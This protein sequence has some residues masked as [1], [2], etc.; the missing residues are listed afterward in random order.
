MVDHLGRSLS[1]LCHHCSLS[2]SVVD[3]DT[4][5]AVAIY[6]GSSSFNPRRI[7]PERS[8]GIALRLSIS[9]CNGILF[10]E[11]WAMYYKNFYHSDVDTNMHIE[12]YGSNS[13]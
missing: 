2:T 4:I 6:V 5:S 11:K 7:A 8:P 9:A 12:K 13:M 10:T 1:W 3:N